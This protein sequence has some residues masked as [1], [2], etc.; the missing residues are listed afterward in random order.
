MGKGIS[1]K[2]NQE[3][4]EIKITPMMVIVI[5]RIFNQVRLSPKINAAEIVTAMIAPAVKTGWTKD[6]GAT[7]SAMK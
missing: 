3:L 1:R 2:T 7:E 4:R 6:K 5:P